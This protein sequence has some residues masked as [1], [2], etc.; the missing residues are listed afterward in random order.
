MNRLP[1]GFLIAVEG[2]DGVGKTTLCEKLAKKIEQNEY[3]VIQT[4]QP[5]GTALGKE[6]RHI[7]HESLERPTPLAEY[8]L[9]AADRAQHMSTLILPAL[10]DHKIVISDRM[11]DS[12]LAYQGYGRGIDLDF[13][14]YVNN[15]A[16][17][18]H[19][20]DLTIYVRLDFSE[21]LNR[22]KTRGTKATAFEK[23]SHAFFKRV[24]EGFETL[25]ATPIPQL[26][27]L[28]GTQTPDILA[29]QA[30]QKVL[31]L[32]SGEPCAKK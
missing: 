9:L 32:L 17:Q 30:Y 24:A 25:Y 8:F 28:E 4:R 21:A 31:L 1:K 7:L 11:G 13:I 12:S 3:P 2:L 15:K 22:L 23:E 14:R 26:L 19:M 10:N 16:M 27:V 5:G 6:I 20:P 18:G 29:D